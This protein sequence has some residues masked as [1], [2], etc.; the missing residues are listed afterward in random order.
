[1][2]ALHSENETLQHA[3]VQ[4]REEVR[5]LQVQLEQ[6]HR[7]CN[8]PEEQQQQPTAAAPPVVKIVEKTPT[9]RT[10]EI[11][12]LKVKLLQCESVIMTL[13]QEKYDLLQL[14]QTLA[15]TPSPEDSP[16]YKAL[17]TRLNEVQASLQQMKRLNDEWRSKYETAARQVE[18]LNEE[19]LQERQQVLDLLSNGSS[20]NSNSTR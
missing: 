2:T 18:A 9:K 13:K 8:E 4:L 3:V 5:Q 17:L 19:R 15:V 1:M 10:E 7:I 11:K 6:F 12:R 14:K 16:Q 20:N